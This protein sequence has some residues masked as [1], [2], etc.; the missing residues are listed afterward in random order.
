MVVF[1]S[2][3]G[4]TFLVARAFERALIRRGLFVSL[5]Q[6]ENPDYAYFA[7]QFETGR[8]FQEEIS[9]VGIATPSDLLSADFICFGSPTYFGNMSG[10][11]KRFFDATAPYWTEGKLSGKICVAFTTAGN[12][13]GGAHLCLQA[14]RTCACHLGMI[15][16][17]YPAQIMADSLQPAYGLVH[18]SG[19]MASDRPDRLVNDSVERWVDWSLKFL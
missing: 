13:E 4:N 6:A 16:L 19:D 8:E 17:P 2:V 11:M 18:Y 1:S 5:K 9:K 10:A 12:R 15:L 7:S 14:I 3:C